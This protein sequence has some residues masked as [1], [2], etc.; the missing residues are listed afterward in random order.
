MEGSSNILRFP[1]YN[2]ITKIKEIFEFFDDKQ[3]LESLVNHL[4]SIS[5][6]KVKVFIGD[7]NQLPQ[8]KNNSVVLS[9]YKA[10]ANLTGI[11]GVVGPVRMDFARVVSGVEF[12]SKQ[13]EKML[14]QEF[15]T[16]PLPIQKQL[17]GK[18]SKGDE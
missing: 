9:T 11:I 1:E 18:T 12:F 17:N 5:D 13:L 3:G 6:G 16:E 15:E 4:P 14:S 8:L 10:G 2:E 7:E